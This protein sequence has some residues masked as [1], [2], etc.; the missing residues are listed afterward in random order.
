M[1]L[2]FLS[3][4]I[5]HAPNPEDFLG[6][7]LKT[8]DNTIL[9]VDFLMPE[10]MS[11]SYSNQIESNASKC[12]ETV[13]EELNFPPPP[14]T[15]LRTRINGLQLDETQQYPLLAVYS[16]NTRES[17]QAQL[18][19]A[20]VEIVA[21]T[22]ST[23]CRRLKASLYDF[24]PSW[25][26]NEGTGRWDKATELPTSI[27][28]EEG[29]VMVSELCALV[30]NLEKAMAGDRWL[31]VHQH[32]KFLVNQLILKPARELGLDLYFVIEILGRF[33]RSDGRCRP[34]S[35]LV[36]Y[37]MKAKSASETD[38][39]DTIASHGFLLRR[40]KLDERSRLILEDYITAYLKSKGLEGL[41]NSRE[42]QD[43][44][45][46]E[47]ETSCW[48]LSD[49]YM[50]FTEG[51]RTLETREYTHDPYETSRA[52]LAQKREERIAEESLLRKVW[53]RRRFWSALG[54]NRF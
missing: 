48:P 7:W 18:R 33:E 49:S 51:L 27:W 32:D 24:D 10:K 5:S 3:S 4:G 14:Y 12:E 39:A 52:R 53:R 9:T 15:K 41:K 42:L 44:S 22:F 2:V 37:W 43:E 34:K 8:A 29:R 46:R 23:D 31:L 50:C 6:E 36:D 26:S 17:R 11:P 13:R 28:D 1:P 35:T 47:H 25:T 38:V 19:W 21:V 40:C 16:K 54:F 45:L 30:H 20:L